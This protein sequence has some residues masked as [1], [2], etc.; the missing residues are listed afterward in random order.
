MCS[1]H[2]GADT[3]VIFFRLNDTKAIRIEKVT[4]NVVKQTEMVPLQRFLKHYYPTKKFFLNGFEFR[5]LGTTPSSD[6]G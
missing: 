4:Q 6:A 2:V 3:N 5:E 1:P